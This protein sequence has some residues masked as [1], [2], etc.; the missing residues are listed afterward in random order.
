VS[1]YASG[2]DPR[3]NQVITYTYDALNRLTGADYETGAYY[4][5]TYDAVGNRLQE[6]RKIN[7]LIPELV[8][9]YEYDE[10]NRLVKVND[11]DYTWD[12]SGN[13]LNDGTT[14]YTYDSASRLTNMKSEEHES[15][16][17]YNGLGERIQQI[18]D[19]K[20]TSFVLDYSIG[21]TQVLQ[22]EDDTND[23]NETYL[24]GAGLIAQEDEE[25]INYYLTDALGEC[26]ADDNR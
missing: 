24:Y 5:Y 14:T 7:T 26:T 18:I 2:S 16:Y 23:T 17:V 8:N 19:G 21:L 22:T 6:T 3:R 11:T 10:A 20:P 12:A 15:S 13:L 1:T 9:T 4:H 25:N